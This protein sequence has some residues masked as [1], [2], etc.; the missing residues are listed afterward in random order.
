MANYQGF[1]RTNY[2]RVTDAKRLKDII[3]HTAVGED[4][5]EL[6]TRQIGD[7]TFYG[8]GCYD[9]ISGL[10]PNWDT[11]ADAASADEDDED[12]DAYFDLFEAELQKILAEDDAI[13]ITE[14]GYE[15]LRYLTAYACVITKSSSACVGLQEAAVDKAKELLRN[16]GWD[17][18]SEY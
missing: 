4:R 10:Y 11:P 17:T 6:F 15:K 3:A 8:F 12:A 7:E 14:V 2:F 1:T 18:T 13:I 5:L 16:P 9:S